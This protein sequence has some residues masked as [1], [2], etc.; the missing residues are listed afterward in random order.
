MSDAKTQPEGQPRNPLAPPTEN[1]AT[2][3]KLAD[4]S[5]LG[6]LS[7]HASMQTQFKGASK[8]E[9]LSKIQSYLKGE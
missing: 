9:C 8:E 5:W 7:S 3:E 4:G 1:E 2:Y 6:T